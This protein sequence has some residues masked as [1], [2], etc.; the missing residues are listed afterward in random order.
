MQDHRARQYD[1]EFGHLPEPQRQMARMGELQKGMPPVAVYVALGTPDDYESDNGQGV[2]WWYLGSGGG[3]S[4]DLAAFQP[5]TSTALRGA[6]V[7]SVLRVR[8]DKGVVTHW[9]L[10][11]QTPVDLRRLREDDFGRMPTLPPPPW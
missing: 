11:P 4:D 2:S 8:F 9:E 7:P 3:E 6:G 5:R 1:R 10:R